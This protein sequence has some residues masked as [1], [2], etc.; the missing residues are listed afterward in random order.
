MNPQKPRWQRIDLPNLP[1]PRV[2]G[3]MVINP[4]NRTII[5]FGGMNSS[6]GY[7]ND[8]WSMNGQKWAQLQSTRLPMK[9]SFV[10]LSWDEARQRVVLFGGAGDGQLFGDTWVFNGVDWT[11]LQP[12]GSPSPRAGASMAYDAARNQT[13][14]FGG[15]ANTGKKF[16]EN[17]NETWIWDGENWQQ[18]SP[19]TL[20]PARAGANLVYDRVR[21]SVLLF[22]GEAGGGIRE[23]TWVWDGANWIEQQPI[24]RPPARADFGMVYHEGKQQV[25]LFGG[26]SYEGM[27]TDTWAWDGQDWLQLQPTQS[28]PP[29]MAYGARLAYLAA[30][31]SVVLY[32]TFRDKTIVSDESFTMVERS[33]IWIL[34]Y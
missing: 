7:L 5:L 11:Q 25:I 8:A 6:S 2:G 18:K 34:N 14:L 1:A 12:S 32:N 4:Q 9:R 31:Q 22:G 33:E 17:Q 26:Q 3:S 27:A 23:D 20:P 10:S 29:Q 15:K 16:P 28:P 13:L 19:A 21:Q 24:H 30:L